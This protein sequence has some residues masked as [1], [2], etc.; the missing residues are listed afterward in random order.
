M[1]PCERNQTRSDVN[2][3]DSS[4]VIFKFECVYINMSDAR[5]YF[6]VFYLNSLR[7]NTDKD[8]GQV[9]LWVS[10]CPQVFEIFKLPVRSFY[11]AI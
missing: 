6:I 1:Y 4:P 3:V 2:E 7:H 5:V 9:I 8:N 10:W 11:G